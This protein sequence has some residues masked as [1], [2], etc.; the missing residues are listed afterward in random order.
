MLVLGQALD[1]ETE[2]H[3]EKGPDSGLHRRCVVE[4]MTRT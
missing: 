4:P 2:A 3:Q 1:K